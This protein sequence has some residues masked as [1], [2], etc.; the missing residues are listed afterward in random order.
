MGP[1][2]GR[3]PHPVPA[4]TE[5]PRRAAST[6]RLAASPAV[7]AAATGQRARGFGV[8]GG[9]QA[10]DQ[11]TVL[12]TSRSLPQCSRP[13]RTC[14]LT[15]LK[16]ADA[17][18]DRIGLQRPHLER[19]ESSA[20]HFNPANP[21]LKALAMHSFSPKQSALLGPPYPPSLILRSEIF[22]EKIPKSCKKQNLN[23]STGN[24][25]YSI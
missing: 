8:H 5:W 19:K 7:E 23:L 22:G 10:E 1:A 4:N 3:G 11:V 6:A 18:P 12:L 24:C 9:L 2:A 17:G 25:L 16:G 20:G 14:S 13:G 15:L 21:L